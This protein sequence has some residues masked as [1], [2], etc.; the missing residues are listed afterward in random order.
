MIQSLPKD[1][2]NIGMA[3][4]AKHHNRYG[5]ECV[6]APIEELHVTEVIA[7]CCNLRPTD[8]HHNRCVDKSNHLQ[9][10]IGTFF[11]YTCLKSIVFQMLNL[12]AQGK[13]LLEYTHEAGLLQH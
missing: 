4:E 7:V 1:G 12:D 10:C 8:H 13:L 6:K 2:D 3:V 11:T 9:H 5:K